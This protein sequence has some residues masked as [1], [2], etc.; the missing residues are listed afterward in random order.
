[1]RD[2]NFGLGW[3]FRITAICG[4]L[5]AAGRY[6]GFL[7]MFAVTSLALVAGCLWY[8]A[9]R[10]APGPT[11]HLTIALILL[12][13]MLAVLFASLQNAREAA[14][15]Q[16]ATKNVRDVA[17]E[18]QIIKQAHPDLDQEGGEL[19]YAKA[20]ELLRQRPALRFRGEGQRR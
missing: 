9:M 8:M 10:R 15:R 19:L 1:M 3:L 5:L 14:R 4:S 18:M 13:P 6:S 12:T 20:Q 16:Q 11:L 17:V 7:F 2:H